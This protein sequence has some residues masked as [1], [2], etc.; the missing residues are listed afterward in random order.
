M[1][2]N[3]GKPLGGWPVNLNSRQ[4]QKIQQTLTIDSLHFCL[5][6]FSRTFLSNEC[7]SELPIRS[8]KKPPDF[9]K[10]GPMK[11]KITQNAHNCA[12][13]ALGSVY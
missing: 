9:V 13:W 11:V 7:A 12:L 1:I 2:Y 10:N 8:D 5:L 6:L 3:I 4:G